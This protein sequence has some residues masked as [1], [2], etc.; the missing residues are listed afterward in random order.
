MAQIMSHL[1]A[2]RREHILQNETAISYMT[3][4]RFDLVLAVSHLEEVLRAIG[5]EKNIQD[6]DTQEFVWK[7]PSFSFTYGY[8]NM[9]DKLEFNK[10]ISGQF[11]LNNRKWFSNYREDIDR[12]S[13][14]ETGQRILFPYFS[15]TSAL[16]LQAL[17][18]IVAIGFLIERPTFFQKVRKFALRRKEQRIYIREPTYE[19]IVKAYDSI[20]FTLPN[21]ILV[22]RARAV[23]KLTGIPG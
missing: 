5:L 23:E 22:E 20:G 11:M 18:Y 12:Y 2:L 17:S 7:K 13:G 10:F 1:F 15:S 19:E 9:I 14:L 6:L 8:I 16:Y 3:Q 21:R 4:I